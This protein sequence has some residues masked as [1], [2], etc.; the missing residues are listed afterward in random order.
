VGPG[1]RHPLSQDGECPLSPTELGAIASP[2]VAALWKRALVGLPCA[3]LVSGGEALP[4]RHRFATA[5]KSFRIG[6]SFLRWSSTV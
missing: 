6:R 1:G 5:Q 4:L 3:L 2:A